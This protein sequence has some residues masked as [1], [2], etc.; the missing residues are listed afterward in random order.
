[1]SY[2]LDTNVVSEL[3][4]KAPAPEVLAWF[5]RNRTGELWLS[6]ITVGEL[7][8]G[9]ALLRARAE[10]VRADRIERA[11]D[12]V[13]GSFAHRIL[14]VDT[15][16]AHRWALFATARVDVSDGLIAATALTHGHTVATRNTK[17]FL[18]TGVA[19]VNPFDAVSDLPG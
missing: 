12:D 8:R 14:A 7:R 5:E 10:T 16:V 18:D 9:I 2:L 1:M 15:A 3:M 17:H 13:E 11:V 19:L 6:V 4:R